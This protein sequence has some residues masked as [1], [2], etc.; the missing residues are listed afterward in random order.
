MLNVSYQ[1]QQHSWL[2]SI[3][4][5]YDEWIYPKSSTQ[6]IIFIIINLTT[7]RAKCFLRTYVKHCET[8]NKAETSP[9]HKWIQ[10]QFRVI[11]HTQP[12]P[13]NQQVI[14]CPDFNTEPH[15]IIIRRLVCCLL[16]FLCDCDWIFWVT[17]N[18][19]IRKALQ[20]TSDIMRSIQNDRLQTERMSGKQKGTNEKEMEMWC[21]MVWFKQKL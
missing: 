4:P 13:M 16:M 10:T 21:R 11:L 15:F 8:N 18:D 6:F 7:E 14:E 5:D 3:C 20:Q 19:G 17:A 9:L 12:D 2:I 1:N